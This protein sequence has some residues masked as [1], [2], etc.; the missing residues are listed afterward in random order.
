MLGRIFPVQHLGTFQK[1]CSAISKVQ[2]RQKGIFGWLG[3]FLGV[4]LHEK[5]S[6]YVLQFWD[7]K[8]GRGLDSCAGVLTC[9]PH[10]NLFQLEQGR[11][12]K[13]QN[14]F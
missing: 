14:Y 2:D 3:K 10:G 6:R 5:S 1:K 11:A 9:H 4:F 8:P 7:L 13:H 12:L